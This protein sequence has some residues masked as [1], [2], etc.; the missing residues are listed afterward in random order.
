MRAV[1]ETVDEIRKSVALMEEAT[2]LNALSKGEQRPRYSKGQSMYAKARDSKWT[3]AAIATIIGAAVPLVAI[4]A[5]NA[6]DKSRL[7]EAEAEIK[8]LKAEVQALRTVDQKYSER[9]VL[10]RKNQLQWR[11]FAD[12]AFCSIGRK[13]SYGCPAVDLLPQPMGGSS[14]PAFQPTMQLT[15]PEDEAEALEDLELNAAPK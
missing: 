10:F 7:R 12:S 13:P 14:A 4:F 15:S 9:F 1:N 6:D 2:A 5:M 3:P 11:T 8:S